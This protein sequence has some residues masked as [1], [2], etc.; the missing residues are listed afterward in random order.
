MDEEQQEEQQ[1]Q[2]QEQPIAPA[3]FT[4][5]NITPAP[6]RPISTFSLFNRQALERDESISAAV[7]KNQ[8]AINSINTALVNIT[9]QVVNLSRSLNVVAEKLQESSTLE[10]LK[11]QQERQ[12]QQRLADLNSRRGIENSLEKNIQGALFAPIQRIGAKTRFTLARLVLFFNTLLGGFLVMRAIKLISALTSGNKEQLE[13]IKEGILKQLTAVGGI[14]LAINGGLVLALRSITRLASFLTQVA[15]TNLLIRPIQLIFKIARNIATA[16]AS[17]MSIGGAPPIVPPNT[18]TKNN[19][20]KGT[21]PGPFNVPGLKTNAAITLGFTIADILSGEDPSRAIAGGTTAFGTTLLFDRVGAFLQKQRNPAI[22]SFGIGLRTVGP[23]IG[24]LFG[25]D[26]GKQGFD[27][28]TQAFGLGSITTNNQGDI[29]TSTIDQVSQNNINVTTVPTSSNMPMSV[30]G[31]AA[32]LMFAPP[33]NPNNPYVLNS[34][35][36]YNVLPVT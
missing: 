17:G 1:Q 14:F 23:F 32:L 13:N 33:S 10:K 36:Q 29:F 15:V 16:I 31:R 26:L 25:Y 12:Q 7:K 6:R 27:N 8:L 18:N 20:G 5:L 3:A 21:K 19:K 2:G 4:N 30:E 24:N 28:V 22:K 34:F 11:L 9:G 35:I